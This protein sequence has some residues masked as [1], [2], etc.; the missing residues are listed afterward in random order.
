MR[1]NCPFTL[2][3]VLSA[4]FLVPFIIFLYVPHAIAITTPSDGGGGG[5]GDFIIPVSDGPTVKKSE[6]WPLVWSEFGEISA[7]R[8][9][10]GRNGCYYLHF[11]TLEPRAL[12]LPVYLKSEMVFYVNSGNGTLSWIDVEKYDDK[13]QQVKLQ[14]G[15]IYR[16]TPGTVFYL[17]NDAKD[18]SN[19]HF[20]FL[21]PQKLQIY[22]IFSDSTNE[23]LH[24]Q[25]DG[26]YVGVQDLVLGFDNKVLQET[27]S[28]PE[29][30]IEELR[31]GERQPLIVEGQPKA[32]SSL[33]EFNTRVIRTLLHTKNA[34]DI[35]NLGFKN[36]KKEKAYNIYKADHDVENCY[37]WCVT[38]TDKQLDVLKDS[39]FGVIMVNLTKGVMMGPH[40]NPNTAEVGIVVH[41]QGMIQVVCPSLEKETYCKNSKFKVEEGDVFLVPKHNP[42]TQISFNDDSFVFMG[43]T[44]N[45]RNNHPQYLAGKSSIFEMLDKWVLTKSFG[46]SNMTIDRIMWAQRKSIILECTSCAEAM[47]QETPGGGWWEGNAF[48]KEEKGWEGEGEAS[49]K[50]KMGREGEGEREASRKEEKGRKGS[51]ASRKEEKGQEGEASRKKEK[52]RK[53]EMA[54]KEKEEM[55][56]GRHAAT[57]VEPI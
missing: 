43:F 26:A 4:Y 22:A 16:L 15:D 40:W 32:N 37:G 30:V 45:L 39:R 35:D 10:D 56:R 20:P 24:E 1:L 21:P 6:R 2:C 41:G 46:V 49:G 18:N 51:K 47:E 5:G 50:E 8:I 25:F 23:L 12:F 53:G 9:K 27:L 17:Q 13:L 33:W 42:M 48:R 19:H 28:V 34:N 3:V 52:G 57:L 29:E 38:V 14:M 11:I 55:R 54:R 44:S 7:V 36:D 31:R